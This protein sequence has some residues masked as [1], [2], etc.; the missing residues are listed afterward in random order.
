MRLLSSLLVSAAGLHGLPALGAAPEDWAQVAQRAADAGCY[1][2]HAE[3]PRRNVP[4]LR[5]IA[6][7]YAAHR[8]RLDSET[9]KALVDRLHHGSMFSHIAAHERLSEEDAARFIRWLVA[10]GPDAR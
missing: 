6:A 3:P 8:G 10:G 4:A 9:E 5:Q 2:C 1:N 7:R